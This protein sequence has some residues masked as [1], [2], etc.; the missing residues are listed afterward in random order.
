MSYMVL[1]LVL[2]G[3]IINRAWSRAEKSLDRSG[4]WL[5]NHAIDHAYVEQFCTIIST[6]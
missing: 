3:R 4:D 6:I 5:G 1:L 2:Q